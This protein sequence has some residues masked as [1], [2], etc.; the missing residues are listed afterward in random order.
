M[1]LTALEFAGLVAFAA[2]GALAAVR[3]RL[4]VFG[5]VVVGLTT[6]LGGGII[7]DVLLGIHPPTSL[8]NWPYLAVCAVTALVVFAFHPQV[9]RLRHAVLLA[10][11]V[12][13]GVFATAGTTLAL[14]AGATGYAACLIGMTSGIGGGALRDLLLREIPLV[15]RKE[16]YAMA[17]LTGAVCVWVGHALSLPAGAVTTVSA[18][19]VVAIRVLT[20]WRHW[21]APVARPPEERSL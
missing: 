17:A 6:A 2:S 1:L 18:A 8:R 7:R 10:D 20:L 16:I 11:A 19:V 21:N 15:L 4:D 14:N 9:A 3:A 5:V 13:L 12:G